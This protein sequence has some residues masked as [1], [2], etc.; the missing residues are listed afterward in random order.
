VEFNALASDPVTPWS[1]ALAERQ[2]R[3][4]SLKGMTSMLVHR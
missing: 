3:L 2:R 1:S 4:I